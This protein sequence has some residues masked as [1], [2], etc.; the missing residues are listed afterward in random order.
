MKKRMS[1]L[2][3]GLF[4][5][6]SLLTVSRLEAAPAAVAPVT[7]KVYNPSGA[8]EMTQTFAPRVDDLNGKTICEVSNGGWEADRIFPAIRDLL[9]KQFPTT[10]IVTYD[11]FPVG[12]TEIDVEKI[13]EMVKAKGCQ[14]AIVGNAG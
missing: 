10:K 5:V 6:A 3:L 13:G 1:W 9:Q 4:L 12:I 2:L 14:A 8:F 11:K 7:L